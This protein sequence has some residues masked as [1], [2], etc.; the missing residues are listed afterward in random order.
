MHDVHIINCHTTLLKKSQWFGF[1]PAH[2]EWWWLLCI[3][4]ID[5]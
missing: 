1:D 5:H 4:N 2:L 3:Y